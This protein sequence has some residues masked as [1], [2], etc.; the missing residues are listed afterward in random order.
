ME[1]LLANLDVEDDF[2]IKFSGQKIRSTSYIL[3]KIAV[4]L[5]PSNSIGHFLATSGKTGILQPD[6]DR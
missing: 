6:S 3:I 2:I 1:Y 4:K 5:L